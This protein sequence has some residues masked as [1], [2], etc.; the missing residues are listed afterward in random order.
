MKQKI[1]RGWSEGRSILLLLLL[2][3]DGNKTYYYEDSRAVPARPSGKG[4]LKWN[5]IT[6]VLVIEYKIRSR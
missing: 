2:L 4:R 1:I 6:T 3:L 5:E